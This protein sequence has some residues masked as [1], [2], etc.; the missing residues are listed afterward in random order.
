MLKE[1]GYDGP[2]DTFR[3]TLAAVKGELFADTTDEELIIGKDSSARFCVE[4]RK[5]LAAPRLGRAFILRSLIG[6]RKNRRKRQKV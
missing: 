2:L 1:Q 5:R 6:I 4:V 3:E